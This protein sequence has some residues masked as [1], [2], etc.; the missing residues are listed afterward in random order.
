[1][2]MVQATDDDAMTADNVR[3]IRPDVTPEP[4]PRPKADPTSALRSKMAA[5]L[6]LLQAR[7]PDVEIDVLPADRSAMQ[8]PSS[9]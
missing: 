3:P 8:L 7:L 9:H 2:T 4:Q 6:V 5:G 1:M